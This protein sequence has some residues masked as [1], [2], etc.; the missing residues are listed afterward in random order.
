MKVQLQ[1]E[2]NKI[3]TDKIKELLGLERF[4]PGQMH[5]SLADILVLIFRFQ[6]EKDKPLRDFWEDENESRKAA[7]KPFFNYQRMSHWF[8]KCANLLAYLVD[9]EKV[10]L[11]GGLGYFDSTKLPMI[12]QLRPDIKVLGHHAGLQ[13]SEHSAKHRFYGMKLHLCVT[14]KG[15][16]VSYQISKG[17]I[18]N[19]SPVMQML[20]KQYGKVLA[21][22]G[23]VDHKTYFKCI[24]HNLK[25]LA[26]PRDNMG[27]SS[28]WSALCVENY[29]KNKKIFKK[30]CGI[31]RFFSRLKQYFGLSIKRARSF[32]AAR[33]RV[34][35][36]LY[37]GTLERK[38]RL[39]IKNRLQ[40]LSDKV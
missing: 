38:G 8:A 1:E 17:N 39:P 4:K 36:A 34:L 13:W 40:V 7:H 23:Y 6:F 3:G 2:L 29:L 37:L 18:A 35:A 27:F 11:A 26:I 16:I 20:Q 30:R 31:E 21:D 28:P 10:P 19:I 24:Q 25:F 15:G 12:N 14:E 9:Q 22:K 33:T 5:L 32:G